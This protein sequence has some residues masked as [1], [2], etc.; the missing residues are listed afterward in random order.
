MSYMFEL[1]YGS[2]RNPQKEAE[3]NERVSRFGG[4]LTY[5]ETQGNGDAARSVCL[6]Y[7]FEELERA[8]AA[9]EAL[10]QRGEH[11]EGPVVYGS[12]A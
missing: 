2:P 1:Y 3:L 7:E 6:T 9:A 5:C 8:E 10:R 12:E 4:R 11:V